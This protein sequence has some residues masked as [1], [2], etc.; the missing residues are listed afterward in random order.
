M[1][2]LIYYLFFFSLFSYSQKELNQAKKIKDRIQKEACEKPF[3]ISGSYYYSDIFLIKD[4][5]NFYFKQNDNNQILSELICDG[6]NMWN[7]NYEYKELTIYSLTEKE[8]KN[9]FFVEKIASQIDELKIVENLILIKSNN[10]WIIVEES[11][12]DNTEDYKIG[13]YDLQELREEYDIIGNLNLHW[14]E[15]SSTV[16]KH[17]SPGFNFKLNVDQFLQQNEEFEIIDFR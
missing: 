15:N 13:T 10:A 5:S 12:V 9:C 6:E 3:F 17:L 1:N 8:K 14:I 7:I 11:Y 4:N 2:K 16:Y